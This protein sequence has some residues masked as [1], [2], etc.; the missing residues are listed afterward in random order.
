MG[1]PPQRAKALGSAVERSE[2]A[3]VFLGR[4]PSRFE[5][6]TEPLHGLHKLRRRA[7]L[8]AWFGAFAHPIHHLPHEILLLRDLHLIEALTDTRCPS[9]NEGE[10]GRG[11]CDGKRYGG[12][13]RSHSHR[14]AMLDSAVSSRREPSRPVLGLKSMGL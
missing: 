7:H 11:D 5:H 4:L 14:G 6:V 10:C 12:D 13:D 2:L 9:H 8:R 3:A 1:R